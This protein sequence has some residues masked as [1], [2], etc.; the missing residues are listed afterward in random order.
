MK[1][2]SLQAENIKKLR[3]VEIKPSGALVQ[4]TGKNGQ[5]KSSV[6]D[7]IWWAICGAEHI[8]SVPIRKGADKAR[9]RLELGEL[10]VERRFTEHGTSLIVENT[11]GARYKS[12]QSVLDALG[13][14]ITLDP[15]EFIGQK[16]KEQYET[17]RRIA[18]L[19]VDF[20]KLTALNHGDFQK[21]TDINRE[22]KTLRAQADGITVPQSTPAEKVDTSALLDQ[23][24]S[25]A[26]VNADI[27]TRKARRQQAERQ[28]EEFRS[29]AASARAQAEALR[30]QAEAMDAR[31]QKA[32]ADA[33]ALAKK[34]VDAEPLPE[35]TDVDGLRMDLAAAEATNKL[36][37]ARMRKAELVRQ[38]EA[39]EAE[40]TVLTETM[41]A[42]EQVKADAIAKAEMPVPG[43]GFGDGIVTLTGVPF[44]QASS[45]EQI[46]VSIAIAMAANPKLRVIRIKEGSLLD[47]DGLALIGKMAEENDYQVWIEKVDSSGKV[48]I[49]I[50]DGSVV[51]INGAEPAAAPAKARRAKAQATAE[52][53][54]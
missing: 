1:I 49:V 32:D 26:K 23:I 54:S 11:E 40:S 9:I 38:A 12:P 3:A 18:K 39:K 24:A 27:E 42:R 21:R 47:D 37:D 20:D 8:Q 15:L 13:G 2:I 33:D 22:A 14:A 5:G 52:A 30:K 46:R 7:A 10:V 28:V 45:A 25:A 6:L 48:G 16:P 36:V 50:D 4:I 51:S 53:A 19:D 17:L 34:L 43:L 29:T 44:D 31:A 35:P 41:A